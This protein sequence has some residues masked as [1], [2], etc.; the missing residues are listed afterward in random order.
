MRAL[1]CLLFLLCGCTAHD[2]R[3]DARLQ[4]INS[5]AAVAAAMPV[6]NSGAGGAAAQPRSEP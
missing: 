1:V 2:V 4:P 6:A 5:P 3:C